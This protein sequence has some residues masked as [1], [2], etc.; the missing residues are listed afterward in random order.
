ML[1]ADCAGTRARRYEHPPAALPGSGRGLG[2][3]MAEAFCDAGANVIISDVAEDRIAETAE[4]IEKKHPGKVLA[5]AANV[6]EEA[7][8]DI[9]VNA[10][11]EKFGSLEVMVA[12]AAIVTAG[13]VMDIDPEK[14]NAM[15]NVNLYGYFISA[16]AACKVMIPKKKGVIVQTN[17]KSGKQGS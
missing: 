15:Q 2:A 3:F 5:V 17:S 7:S 1:T 13:A 10:A 16:R 6:T 4:K 8:M 12:N 14:W 9:A 11:V